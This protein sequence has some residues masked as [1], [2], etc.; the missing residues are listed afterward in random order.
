MLGTE[1]TAFA[2]TISDEE[3][4][5]NLLLWILVWSELVTFA[6]LLIAFMVMSIINSE[7]VIQLRAHLS[8]GLAATNTVVLL[9]SGWQAAIAVRQRHNAKAV[10]RPLLG[11]AFFGLAFVVVKL[12]EY[13]HEIQFV[14]D[15]AVGAFFELYFLLTGFHLMHVLFGSIIL[16]LVA[17]RSSASNVLL[18]TT[19]WHAI[20]LVWLVMFPVLYL[21]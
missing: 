12:V 7:G 8:P 3:P 6:I 4:A 5:D 9:I 13:S 10:R 19:L 21:A 18:I 15:E 14:G 1:D 11:A 16:A 20:D 17:W 2:A